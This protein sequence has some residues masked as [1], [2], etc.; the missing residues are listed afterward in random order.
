MTKYVMGRFTLS[1]SE[2]STNFKM[3]VKSQSYFPWYRKNYP[4]RICPFNQAF[5]H[6]FPEC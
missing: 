3:K 2:K 5:Y 4:L 1:E 6:P